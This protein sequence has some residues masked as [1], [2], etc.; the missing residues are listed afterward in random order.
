MMSPEMA[1]AMTIVMMVAM[2]I[3]S[4]APTLWRHHRHLR[5]TRAP[6][7]G[8]LTASFAAGYALVWVVLG[9]G[10]FVLSPYTDGSPRAWAV[11]LCAGVVQ[12][13]PWKA[14]RLLRC[15][16]SCVTDDVESRSIATAWREGCR[17]GFDCGLSCAAPMAIL[18]VAGL[19]DARMMA[20]VT[21]AITAERL[22]P[23]GERIARFTG[24]VALAA[25]LVLAGGA[26]RPPGR[27]TAA[28][29]EVAAA[30]GDLDP[31]CSHD[32]SELR[33]RTP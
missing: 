10:L 20:V 32:G 1:A 31:R 28:M 5:M 23:A 27:P 30:C 25:G 4:V 17:L 29:R 2:M 26:R 7:A 3:P 12:C 16:D 11:I 15:R 21:A 24:A 19:A 14:R 33:E 22:A 6:H 18:L 13:S 8:R 9:A